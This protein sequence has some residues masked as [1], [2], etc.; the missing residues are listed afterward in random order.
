M[1][2]MLVTT[3]LLG[4][5][6]I[7]LHLAAAVADVTMDPAPDINVYMTQARAYPGVSVWLYPDSEDSL[8]YTISDK[9]TFT[10]SAPQPPP[11]PYG[12]SVLHDDYI[13]LTG[14]VIG[15][16][17]AGTWQ[18]SITPGTS[19]DWAISRLYTVYI[20][21]LND[22]GNQLEANFAPLWS[23]QAL[24]PT[25]IPGNQV[26]GSANDTDCTFTKDVILLGE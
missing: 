18:C 16:D 20:H 1:S 2:R 24:G 11:P 15:Q 10:P 21:S 4:A 17:V 19:N 13:K 3:A 25:G 5:L 23:D 6:L 8:Y 26:H 14:W 9:D 12:G 22:T 7:A